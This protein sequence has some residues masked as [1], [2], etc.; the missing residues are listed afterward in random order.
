MREKISI[1]TLLL[2]FTIFESHAQYGAD[3]TYLDSIENTFDYLPLYSPQTAYIADLVLI[4]QGGAARLPYTKEQIAPYVYRANDDGTIDWLF[5][6]FLFLEFRTYEGHSFIQEFLGRERSRARRTEWTRHLDKVFEEGKAVSALNDVLA[7]L[8]EAGHKPLRKR[9]V[10]LSLPEP[11]S[12]Q[13]D[14]GSL[15]GK[16]M[17]FSVDEDRLAALRWYIDD[18]IRRFSE[19]N[20]Q[21]IELAGFYWTKESDDLSERLVMPTSEYI[22]SKGYILNWIPNWG[23][24]RGEYWRER[25]FNAA[26]IQPNTFF[27]S[28]RSSNLPRVCTYASLHNMGLE[29]EF[30]HNLA[31]EQ[32]HQKL[33]D[34]FDN[35]EKYKV[36]EKSAIAYYEGGRHFLNQLVYGKAP[37]LQ[38]LYKRLT[39][40]VVERQNRADRMH[41]E[42]VNE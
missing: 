7:G 36:I 8:N 31:K 19:K 32:F 26:Y 10:V 4:Y 13:K 39:D 34:Y 41:L 27:K 22:N 3:D 25:G 35:F 9:K 28:G 15:D 23:P 37:G 5:D 2:V 11:M 30:D 40:I 20:Y 12:G 38:S 24:H 14:W 17:D 1:I 42:R 21:H 33:H 18:V 6:G 29:V 16:E